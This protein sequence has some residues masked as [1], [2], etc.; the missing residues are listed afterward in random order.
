M[1]YIIG[2][3]LFVDLTTLAVT[4]LLIGLVIPPGAGPGATRHFLWISRHQWTEL[5]LFLAIVLIFLLVLHGLMN[6]NWICESNKRYFGNNW[7]QFLF[8]LSG[9]WIGIIIIGWLVVRLA[10]H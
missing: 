8:G 1:K 9:A 2:A 6:W 10:R 3:A 5:H 7:K 4:G